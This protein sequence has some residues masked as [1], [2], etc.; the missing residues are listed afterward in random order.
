MS[1][2]CKGCGSSNYHLAGKM[3]GK[4]RYRCKDCNRHYT[5]QDRREK[6]TDAQ[7]LQALLLF[8][9]G[10]S[11]RSI[12]EIIGT[13]NVTVLQWIRSIGRRLKESVLS[14]PMEEAETLDVIEIDEMWHYTKKNSENYGFG[15]LTLVPRNASSPAKSVLVVPKH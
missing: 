6:Y 10:L 4:Q 14:Q 5:M 8:R 11:L 13:N 9:K 12:A 2:H 1:I 7:R 3:N 15:L